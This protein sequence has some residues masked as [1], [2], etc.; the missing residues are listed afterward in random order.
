M[1]RRGDT[2]TYIWR[3]MWYMFLRDPIMGYME[4]TFGVGEN[5]YLS[6]AAVM[7]LCGLIPLL[8][9]LFLTGL[10]LTKALRLRSVLGEERHFADMCTGGVIALLCGAMFEGYLLGTLTFPV[11]GVYVYL[12]MLNF[13]NDVGET[14]QQ[15]ALY[16]NEYPGA[17]GE[18]TTQ[19]EP[20]GE[21]Y[22]EQ[23]T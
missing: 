4:G 20:V 10:A 18:E 9:F 11:F 23:F 12:T 2:R 7:G 15:Q 14:T 19:H 16:H 22:L 1:M 6:A 13:A 5:S 17:L 21:P 3:D 8:T